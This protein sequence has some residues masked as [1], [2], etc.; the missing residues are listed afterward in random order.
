MAVKP[1]SPADQSA[2]QPQAHNAR[3]LQPF[4]QSRSGLSTEPWEHRCA[5][6][7]LRK[8]NSQTPSTDNCSSW[9]MSQMAMSTIRAHIPCHDADTRPLEKTNDPSLSDAAILVTLAFIVGGPG[10]QITTHLPPIARRLILARW[11]GRC[12]CI[13]PKHVQTRRQDQRDTAKRHSIGP[14]PKHQ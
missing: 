13:A 9:V 5:R 11:L 4:G 2:G 6:F 8:L 3:R 1:L 14:F 10:A 12:A 7:W